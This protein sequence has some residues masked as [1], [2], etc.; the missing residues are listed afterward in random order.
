MATYSNLELDHYYLIKETEDTDITLVQP[1]METGE[2]FLI[3]HL[4]EIETTVWKKKDDDIA[5][6]IEELSEEQVAEFESLFEDDEDD[7][8]NFEEPDYDF[9]EEEEEENEEENEPEEK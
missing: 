1:V 8:W 3:L 7:N 5:E 6:I 2:C 9:E 4:D